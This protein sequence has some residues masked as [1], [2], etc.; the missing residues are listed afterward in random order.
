MSPAVLQYQPR[1][2]QAALHRG[3]ATHRDSI[4][5]CHRRA[6]K[7]VAAVAELIRT[8]FKC[9][10][11]S[12]RVAYVAPTYGMAKRIAWDYFR[13]MLRDVPHK[14]NI[15][16]LTIDLPGNRRIYL[17]GADNPARLRGMYLDA[18]AV[19]EMADCAESLIG[20]VL[21]PCLSERNGRL[22]LI[23]TVKGPNH[24]WRTYERAVLDPAWFTANLRP[25]D[26]GALTDEQLAYLRKEMSDDEYRG[27]MLNDPNAGIRG[28]FYGP[29][30]HRLQ[31]RGRITRVDYDPKLLVDV[32]MDLGFADGTAIWFCQCL[33]MRE[34]RVLKFMEFS[35][36]SFTEVLRQVRALPFTFGRWIGPHD[37]AVHEYTTGTTRLQAARELGIHFEVAPKLPVN[38][39]IDAGIRV[40]DMAWFDAE[41]TMGGRDRLGLYRSQYDEKH[42]TLSRTPLHDW[43]SHAADA[44][45]Y[46][47]V[48]T[49]GRSADLFSSA[50]LQYQNNG[51]AYA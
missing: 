9:Q 29:T 11:P 42:R 49:D 3:W 15:G 14:A 22:M 33:G 28:S 25:N 1:P 21:R 50:P 38:E 8:V 47:A 26:T 41:G 2:F 39:G 13:Q 40:L 31:E 4:V 6:G 44:W 12:P 37:L 7:T 32:A 45:R 46:F 48:A 17:L 30:L 5:L 20:E 19:D 18:A 35:Q 51:S 43:T 36:T 27:E 10:L 23:G 16:E 24:F 34:V